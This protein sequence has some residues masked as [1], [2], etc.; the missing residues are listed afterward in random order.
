MTL[1]FAIGTVFVLAAVPEAHPAAAEI[2]MEGRDGV[3]CLTLP[4][5]MMAKGNLAAPT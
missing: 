3:L 2:H 5:T 4:A 1:S